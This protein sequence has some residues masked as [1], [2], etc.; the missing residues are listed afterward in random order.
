MFDYLHLKKGLKVGANIHDANGINYWED[1]Y[2]EACK[3]MGLNPDS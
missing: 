3:I 2:E 1:T